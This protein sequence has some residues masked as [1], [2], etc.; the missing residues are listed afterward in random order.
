M[1]GLRFHGEVS[2][3]CLLGSEIFT[4]KMEAKWS[5]E[6]LVSYRTASKFRRPRF[7]RLKDIRIGTCNE[8]L[9]RKGV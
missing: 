8:S 9:Y 5:S 6:T 1:P 7:E 4:M 2:S 3:R